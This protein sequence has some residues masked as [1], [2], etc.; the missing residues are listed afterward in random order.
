[1]VENST[2]LT[3]CGGQ[4]A[5]LAFDRALQFPI[6]REAL[7][8]RFDGAPCSMRMAA[9]FAITLSKLRSLSQNLRIQSVESR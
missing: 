1:M 9:M 4:E 6:E 2:E 3:R 7:L 8:F 5:A